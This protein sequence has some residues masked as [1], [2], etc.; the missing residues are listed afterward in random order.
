MAPET[1]ARPLR[2]RIRINDNQVTRP[3]WP[4]GSQCH[5][6]GAVNIVERGTRPL[7]LECA[8]LLPEGEILGQAFRA[9]EKDGPEGTLSV[10]RKMSRRNMAA[11]FALPVPRSQAPPPG[12]SSRLALNSK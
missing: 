8:N 12:T 2:D 10:T 3:T 7:A 4:E 1:F 9:G 6:E 5:P 11:E